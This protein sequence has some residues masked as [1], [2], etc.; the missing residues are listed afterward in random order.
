MT[1]ETN[2]TSTGDIERIRDEMG[3][4]GDT[5]TTH[6]RLV[7]RDC[8]SFVYLTRPRA[9]KAEAVRAE[10]DCR[11]GDPTRGELPPDWVPINHYADGDAD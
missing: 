10:C 5:R 6:P 11:F 8:D 1:N 9:F 4:H 7:C 2:A 3:D